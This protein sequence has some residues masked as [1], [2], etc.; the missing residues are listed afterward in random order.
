MRIYPAIRARMG[1]WQY[2]MVRM[3]M[4]EVARKVQLSQD[5]YEDRTIRD[6]VQRELG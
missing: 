6:A 5:I 1:D 4:R 2:Y 3:K